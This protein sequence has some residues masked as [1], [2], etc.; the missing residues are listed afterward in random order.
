MLLVILL[1]TGCGLWLFN[2]WRAN[3]E[4]M[5]DELLRFDRLRS[6][7]SYSQVIARLSP[8]AEDKVYD[9]LFLIGKTEAVV[10]AD[11][12]TQLKQMAATRGVE[13]V[14]AGDVQSKTEGPITLVGESLEM[15]G[16]ITDIFSFVQDIEEGKPLLFLDRLNL[17]TNGF[18]G[19]EVKND[20]L[21]IV[22][23]QVFGAVRSRHLQQ[24]ATAS[25]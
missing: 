5:S 17:R 12:L 18:L 16:G 3:T 8:E 15:S 4:A 22:E 11:L 14:R 20:T 1:L 25:H 24:N 13:V 9:D 6:V 19:D 10:S 2:V 7:A 21:L 23:M